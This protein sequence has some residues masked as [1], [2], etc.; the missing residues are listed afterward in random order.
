MFIMILFDPSFV[1]QD[2]NIASLTC[3]VFFGI[4]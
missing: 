2:L 4:F 3:L 1:W